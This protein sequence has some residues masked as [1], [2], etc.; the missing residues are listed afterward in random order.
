MAGDDQFS[1]PLIDQRVDEAKL[2]IK[3][4]DG[5]KYHVR[6]KTID[7]DGYEGPWGDVQRIDVPSKRS[8]W[9]LLGLP[10]IPLLL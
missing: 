1:K 2:K 6:I 3:R 4:P 8:Y 10:L 9:W 7:S 5:G